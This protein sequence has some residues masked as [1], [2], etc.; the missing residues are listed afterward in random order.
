MGIFEIFM[1][2]YL[3]I[4]TLVLNK[5]R[6]RIYLSNGKQRGLYLLVSIA[7]GVLP[8]IYVSSIQI[9]RSALGVVLVGIGFF[10][11]AIVGSRS[12]AT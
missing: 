10:W 11:F 9:E 5:W 8:F 2:A 1:L 4:G 7:M 3:P 6:K 12:T